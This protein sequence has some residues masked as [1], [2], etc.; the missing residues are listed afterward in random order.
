MGASKLRV[1]PFVAI[2]VA[3]VVAGLFVVLVGSDPPNDETAQTNLMGQPAPEAQGEL[4]DGSTFQLS[5]RKGDWVILN[6]FQSSCIPC[7]EE[8]PELVD[9][10]ASQPGDGGGARFYSVVWDDS[11]ENVEEFFAREGGDWPIVYDDGGAISV[12]FGVTAVPETWIIDPGG[13]IRYRT[14]ATVTAESLGAT[15]QQLRERFG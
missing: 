12:A 13:V 1:A 2:A 15:M 7:Q 10:V 5:R 9:F 14:I 6:F 8:H 3:L 11:R 4:A